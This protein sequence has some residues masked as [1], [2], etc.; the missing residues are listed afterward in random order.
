MPDIDPHVARLLDASHP[1]KNAGADS[2]DEDALIAEL[3][4]DDDP[5]FAAMRERRR[6]QL[7]AE[8]NRAKEMKAG[9]HGVYSIITDEK[10]LMD[11]TTSTKWCVVH[12]M[13]PDFNRCRI[14]DEK[15]R[16]LAEKHFDT[17]FVGI[18]VENAP[19]LV[20]KLQIKVLPCV[21]AFLDGVGADRIIGFEGIGY[22]PDNF[23]A[24]ELEARLLQAG[25]LTRAKMNEEDDRRRAKSEAKDREE[26]W[27][28]DEWD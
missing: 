27:D 7:H 25:V 28:E 8:L 9:A 24:S 10:E 18:D 14:M 4:E 17:R 6:Q 23:T 3:E 21:I 11:I 2:D 16:V 20:V 26:E 13:K 19:F 12:F 5:A 1:G 22:K 15:L